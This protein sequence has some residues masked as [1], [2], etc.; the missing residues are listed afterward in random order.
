MHYG[1]IIINGRYWLHIFLDCID[2]MKNDLMFE[3]DKRPSF[4]EIIED[5][6]SHSFQLAKE[7]DFDEI[8]RQYRSLC[9]YKNQLEQ[10]AKVK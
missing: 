2:L 5:M 7:V 3:P 9:R 4:D 6:K 8:Q 10:K 1:N